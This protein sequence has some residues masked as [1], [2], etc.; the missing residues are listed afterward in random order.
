METLQLKVFFFRSTGSFSVPLD[1]SA[2]REYL[3]LAGCVDLP[4][5]KPGLKRITGSFWFIYCSTTHD[6]TGLDQKKTQGF[7]W[8]P[9]AP[10]RS[11]VG[12]LGLIVTR[13]DTPKL[14]RTSTTTSDPSHYSTAGNFEK[15]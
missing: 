7:M 13:L 6:T 14:K 2:K 10:V 8:I 4:T 15:N 3:Q 12:P 9:I 5:M 1:W 11:Q